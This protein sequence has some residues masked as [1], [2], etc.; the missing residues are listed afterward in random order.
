[1]VIVRVDVVD[2]PAGRFGPVGLNVALGPFVT[3]GETTAESD[4]VLANWFRLD[5]S[6]IDEVPSVGTNKTTGFT[7]TVKSGGV[8]ILIV[9]VTVLVD[10]LITETVFE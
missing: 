4:S 3:I 10:P 8:K 6:T 9:E 2:P 7:E 1:M 5:M